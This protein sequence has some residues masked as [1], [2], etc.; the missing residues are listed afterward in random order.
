MAELFLARTVGPEGF[1]KLVVLKK[2]L[3]KLAENPKFVR[4][5]L[6]EARLAAALDH[7]H[8]AH[9][10]DLGKVDNS[11]FFAME[12]VHGQDL[13]AAVKRTARLGKRL[14]IDHA[15]QIAHAVASALHYAH[16]RRAP[17]G[18]LLGI[19]HRDVSPS[20][21]LIAY[22]GAIKL[23]DF[24]VAKAATSSVKTRTGTL[25]GKISYMSPEQARGSPIDRRSDVFALGT[26]LWELVTSQR[27]FK[28][29]ND[30]ATIQRII[31]SEAEPPTQL[32]PDCPPELETIILKALAVDAAE[33]YQSAEELQLDLEELA[34]EHKLVQSTVAL[35][36]YMHELFAD[37]IA[38]WKA[39]QASGVT[40]TDHVAAAPSSSGTPGSDAE[41]YLVE[42][43]ID[44]DDFDLG[45]DDTGAQPP[46][47]GAFEL[48]LPAPIPDTTPYSRPTGAQ[49]ARMPTSPSRVASAPYP[50]PG[51]F[52]IAPREWRSTGPKGK[53]EQRIKRVILG[54][55]ALFAVLAILALALGGTEPAPPPRP[56]PIVEEP[57]AVIEMTPQPPPAK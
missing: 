36:A 23:V 55:L 21:V 44:E 53:D 26:V 34:R 43:E 41:P 16:E 51:A 47:H 42:E 50:D 22:D 48:P 46:I 38:A 49:S 54:G 19:V 2:I 39:A 10:Y 6:D 13:H 17:D 9:V 20:N 30:L 8:I 45:D 5:F 33:R 31:N 14:P 37:E 18:S 7:P 25:K 1:E 15:V 24:G 57:P 3:P 56:A 4:L 12:Y 32:R 29:E 40:L 11:Y 35:R 28:A 52:P 27:L